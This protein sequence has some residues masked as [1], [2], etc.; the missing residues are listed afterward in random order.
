MQVCGER[1]GMTN[2][3]DFQMAKERV[4]ICRGVRIYQSMDR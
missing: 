1:D 3:R 2:C 4:S